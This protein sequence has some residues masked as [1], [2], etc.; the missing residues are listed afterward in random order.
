MC[1]IYGTTGIYPDQDI[2]AKLNLTRFRGPDY[3]DLRRIGR[4]TMGHNRLAIVD[5]DKR[6]NQP[7]SYK[8]LT[9]VFNGEIYNYLSLRAS[10]IKIGYNFSTDSDT[11][12]IAAAYLAYGDRCVEYLNGMFAFVIYD[13]LSNSLFGARDRIGKK[14]FYYRHAANEFEFASQPAALARDKNLTPDI[15]AI[16]RYF[17]WG[18][19]PEPY[20]AW[21]EIK[22]IPA[23]HL[24]RYNIDKDVLTIKQYWDVDVENTGHFSGNYEHAKNSLIRLLDDAVKIRLRADVSLGVFLSGGI[25][26]SLV[27]A[28]ATKHV[29]KLKTFSVKFTNKDF[30]ESGYAAGVANYLHT[31]HHTVVCDASEGISLIQD[32]GNYYDEPFAD[33]SAIPSLLLSKY[34]KKLVTVALTGDGGDESFMGY[35]RYRWLNHADL[36]FKY[37]LWTRKLVSSALSLSANDKVQRIAQGLCTTDAAAL[38]A[39]MLGGLNYKWLD[40]PEVGLAVPYMDVWSKKGLSFLQKMSAFDIKTY[41]NGDINT[42]VDRATMAFAIEARAPL[43][44]YRVISFAQQLP[45]D[46]KF[47]THNQK[48]ILKDILYRHIPSQYFDRPKRGFSL[49]IRHWFRNELKE[50]VLDELSVSSLK[51]IPGVNVAEVVSMIQE[52][53]SGKYNRSVQI[54]KLLVFKQWQ[55]N[56]HFQLSIPD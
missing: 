32:F 36:L 52:H 43:M 12:V 22:K 19:V 40:N 15:N 33:S 28:I 4:V 47:K 34:T 5:L 3:S 41:L 24:F 35:T 17:V 26:S 49:P 56:Q 7:L 10:L 9:I 42:K 8:H 55:Q 51:D 38:Y 30:D 20:S 2:I 39:L 23:G 50:Y 11:E 14:P 6:S 45:A 13:S 21:R 16:H 46:F 37:P 29:S 1:G 25:D 48:R 31:D 44:D 27:A 53:M 54:W 18:Y